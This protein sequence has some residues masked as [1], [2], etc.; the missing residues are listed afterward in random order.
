VANRFVR[1]IKSGEISTIGE[2]KSEFKALAKLSHPDLAGEDAGQ[3]DFVAL[4]SEY[5]AALRNFQEHRFGA[6]P[7]STNSSSPMSD[8]AW[9]CLAILMKRG[10]PKTPRHEKEALRYDYARW[11]FSEA[12]GPAL[13][14]VFES[15][16]AELLALREGGG[17]N[18]LAVELAFLR[19][20][21]AF[22]DRSLSPMRTDIV[23]SLGALGSDPSV[24]PAFRSFS[25]ALAK[26]LGIGIELGP[27]PRGL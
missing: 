24:G 7:R 27:S 16:D 1:R 12:L 17:V 25:R 22:R 2:L 9:P 11:R 5:E 21:L 26:E 4:R 14:A 13:A 19:K 3:S 10:F 8:E 15:C 18:T 6:A 20:L 23:L